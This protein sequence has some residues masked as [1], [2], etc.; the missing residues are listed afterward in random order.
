LIANR[1]KD[2]KTLVTLN[3]DK[4]HKTKGCIA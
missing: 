4:V 3:V 1:R 2:G